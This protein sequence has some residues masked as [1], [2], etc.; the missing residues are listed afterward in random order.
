MGTSPS[1]FCALIFSSR[2]PV[3]VCFSARPLCM[4]ILFLFNS[5]FARNWPKR[6]YYD[7]RSDVIQTV[8][9]SS[10]PSNE[11]RFL[12]IYFIPILLRW[13]YHLGPTRYVRLIVRQPLFLPGSISSICFHDDILLT[14]L[15]RLYSFLI[16]THIKAYWNWKSFMKFYWI[17]L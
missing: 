8:A 14:G 2:V 11:Y 12:F 3:D 17:H 15:I 7:T 16:K 9:L 13:I 5:M 1:R 10:L 4:L 6:I